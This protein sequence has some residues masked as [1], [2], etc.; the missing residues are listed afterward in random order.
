MKICRV[1]KL[2]EPLGGRW[3]EHSDRLIQD[4]LLLGF[5]VEVG[6]AYWHPPLKIEQG[7]P[8][9]KGVPPVRI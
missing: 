1:Y 6:S 7:S 9:C 3:F 5:Q 8:L 2:W 4:C